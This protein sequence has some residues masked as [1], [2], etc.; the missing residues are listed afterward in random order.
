MEV[1]LTTKELANLFVMFTG[2]TY[3][4]KTLQRR[5]KLLSPLERKKLTVYLTNIQHSFEC[6]D[7]MIANRAEIASDPWP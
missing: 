6:I 5:L 3:P 4:V 2:S 7:D 1:E